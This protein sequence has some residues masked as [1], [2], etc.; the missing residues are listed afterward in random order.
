[1]VGP[2]ME[3]RAQTIKTTIAG[4][5]RQLY[6]FVGGPYFFSFNAVFILSVLGPNPAESSLQKFPATVEVVIV[7]FSK[8][9]LYK[10][11]PARD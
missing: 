8:N 6:L 2:S 3:I 11:D 4:L 10:F 7:E 5:S 9:Q 1:M